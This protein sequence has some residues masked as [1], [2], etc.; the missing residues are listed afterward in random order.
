MDLQDCKTQIFLTVWCFF[1]CFHLKYVL[2]RIKH[3][4]CNCIEDF[5]KSSISGI[6]AEAVHY[7]WLARLHNSSFSV[8]R[9][10]WLSSSHISGFSSVGGVLW[11]RNNKKQ[12]LITVQKVY[13]GMNGADFMCFGV[14]IEDCVLKFANLRF[15]FHPFICIWHRSKQ[16]F[17]K[18]LPNIPVLCI[19]HCVW[20]RSVGSFRKGQG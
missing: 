9:P 16:V 13:V 2:L 7:V 15:Y 20:K 19:L 17:F 5:V 4:T 6:K 8:L 10:D 3:L 1:F 14:Q 12:T 11:E 18:Q